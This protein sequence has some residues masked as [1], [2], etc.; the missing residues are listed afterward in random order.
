[1]Q[2]ISKQTSYIILAA[3]GAAIL[4][5]LNFSYHRLNPFHLAGKQFLGFYSLLILATL[6][7]IR[8]LQ[9]Q[10][11]RLA[12][13]VNAFCLLLGIARLI[14]G[15]WHHKP[16]GYLILLLLFPI[17]TAFRLHARSNPA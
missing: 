17:I 14:Q 4:L 2:T 15:L 13:L 10:Q 7:N 6:G 16:V 11:L 3:S 12:S 8:L 5:F 9:Q 1:M